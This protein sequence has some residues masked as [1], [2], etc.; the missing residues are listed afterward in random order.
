MESTINY[1]DKEEY[2]SVLTYSSIIIANLNSKTSRDDQQLIVK[3]HLYKWYIYSFVYNNYSKAYENLSPALKISELNGFPLARV[4]LNY[5]CTY[6]TLA[7]P[8]N[9]IELYNTAFKYLSKALETAKEEHNSDVFVTS[10]INLV[11]VSA[12]IDSVKSIEHHYFQYTA[13]TLGHDHPLKLFGQYY[14]LG[15]TAKMKKQYAEALNWF[16][17]QGEIVSSDTKWTRP[18]IESLSMQAEILSNMNEVSQAIA[19]LDKAQ[20]LSEQLD[21]QDARLNIYQ[22]K[23]EIFSDAGNRQKA[24]AFRKLYYELKDSMRNYQH[25]IKVESFDLHSKIDNLEV[26]MLMLKEQKYRRNIIITVITAM[27]LITIVFIVILYFKNRILT[28][29]NQMLYNK[30]LKTLEQEETERKLRIELQEEKINSLSTDNDIDC[31]IK[32]IGSNLERADLEEIMNKVNYIISTNNEIYSPDFSMQTLADMT[33]VNYK[34]LSQA[35]NE[36]TNSNFNNFINE[37]RVDE[38][39]RRMSMP[40]YANFTL[41]TIGNSVGFKTR[42]TFISAFKRRTG[43]TPSVWQKIMKKTDKS[44]HKDNES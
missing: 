22:Q 11:S 19:I 13:D 9:N 5:G 25:I 28:Q 40:D 20:A 32:Y 33:G 8:Y 27:V 24:D 43:L 37:I 31:T 14:Y 16:R 36:I 29:N 21:M 15:E 35:I 6:L 38:A 18:Y 7:T 44:N 3:A 12:M 17:K 26:E 34:N 2:D 1:M 41:E 42:Q 4:F 23:M 10:F 39:C 30:S